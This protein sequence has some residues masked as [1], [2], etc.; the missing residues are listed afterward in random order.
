MKLSV[1]MPVYNTA[2]Y[3]EQ[4]IESIIYQTYKDIEVIL[5][6]DGSTDG[7]EKICD[8]YARSYNNFKVIHQ[9]NSGNVAA[10]C[11]GAEE[12][13]GE[14]LTFPDSDDWI[15]EDMYEDL[16]AAA[17]REGCDI[18]SHSGYIIYEDEKYHCIEDTTMYGTYVKGINMN[19]F[20][21]KMM[22]DEEKE[23]RGIHPSLCCK[24][25]RKSILLQSYAKLDRNISMGGDAAI[26]YPCCLRAESVSI[27]KGYKYFYRIRKKSVSHSFDISSFHKIN[28][29]YNYLKNEFTQFGGQYNL[30]EQLKKYLWYFLSIQIEKN[31]SLKVKKTYLFPYKSVDRD[32]RIIL[33]GAGNVGQSYHEQIKKNGY[34][35]I[36][37]WTDQN[38]YR[39]SEN[40][41][42]PTEIAGM[43]YSQVVIAIKSKEIAEEII[44][45]LIGLGVDQQKIMWAEP[46][47]MSLV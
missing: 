26:F 7:S 31:F 20:L 10:R 15:A 12:A 34:C 8:R 25:I 30:V 38:A 24:V 37:A 27:V 42:S 33:Y 45:D 3:L 35:D 29:F 28:I 32:S 1:I 46:C 11:R 9:K 23:K 44:H 13:A 40:I 47:M 5:V 43:E 41:I 36:V 19:V 18:V 39:E 17:E 21:K 16:M 4:C 6:D 22:Y 14:Y 2:Q